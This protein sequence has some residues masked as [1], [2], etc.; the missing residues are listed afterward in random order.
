MEARWIGSGSHSV[1]A[2]ASQQL[3]STPAAFYSVPGISS[4]LCAECLFILRTVNGAESVQCLGMQGD[5]SRASTVKPVGCEVGA[6][7]WGQV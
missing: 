2:G 5:W 1:S 3:L 4:T 7:I 6:T